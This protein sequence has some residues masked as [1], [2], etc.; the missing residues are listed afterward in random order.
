MMD[1]NGKWF[2]CLC[3]ATECAR[4]MRFSLFFRCFWRSLSVSPWNSYR[5]NR[6]WGKHIVSQATKSAQSEQR[7]VSTRFR[8]QIEN[9]TKGNSKFKWNTYR[10]KWTA[11]VVSTR[12]KKVDNVI[13]HR[14]FPPKNTFQYLWPTAQ[15]VL[16]FQLL[17]S[18]FFR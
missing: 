12:R 7:V 4:K 8:L 9:R 3:T 1:M 10:K 17:F 6:N 15:I 14:F 18:T 5:T 2:L 11:L 13:C 16:F